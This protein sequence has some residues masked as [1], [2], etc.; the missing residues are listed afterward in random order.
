MAPGHVEALP[1]T[2]VPARAQ[3]PPARGAEWDE[4]GGKPIE[5]LRT[6]IFGTLK[7]A[8]SAPPPASSMRRAEESAKE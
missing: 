6:Y 8:F 3:V 7:G 4:R 1:E 5:E 2:P